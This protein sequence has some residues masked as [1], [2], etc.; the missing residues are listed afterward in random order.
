MIACTVEDQG[1]DHLCL[2]LLDEAVAGAG[3]GGVEERWVD[4]LEHPVQILAGAIGIRIVTKHHMS[5]F[6]TDAVLTVWS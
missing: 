3:P 6:V 2:L 5:Y 4:V 1:G